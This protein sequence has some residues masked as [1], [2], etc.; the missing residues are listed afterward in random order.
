MK[1][2]LIIIVIA[3]SSSL[4]INFIVGPILASYYLNQRAGQ[5]LQVGDY[6]LKYDKVQV[7]RLVPP[8]VSVQKLSL[9]DPYGFLQVIVPTVL[10]DMEWQ[11]D[12][13]VS[14]PKLSAMLSVGGLKVVAYQKKPDDAPLPV[15]P[16]ANA[17]EPTSSWEQWLASS[18]VKVGA[19]L[20]VKAAS[21]VYRDTGDQVLYSLDPFDLEISLP[22][23]SQ[24]EKL[25]KILLKGDARANLSPS[26]PLNLPIEID[27]NPLQ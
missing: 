25:I 23:L 19:G 14:R 22:D 21:V 12:S 11:W 7:G 20:V 2:F 16:E 4:A 10:F 24:P 15:P 13:D 18:F 1:K 8:N 5:N 17:Q 3:L 9:Q 27:A 26:F 6:N